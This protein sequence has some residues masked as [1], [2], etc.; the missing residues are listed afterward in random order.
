[1][2]G[3]LID[4]TR[5]IANIIPDWNCC[6]G[7]QMKVVVCIENP[8]GF[9]KRKGGTGDIPSARDITPWKPCQSRGLEGYQNQ[10]PN[11]FS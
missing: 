10:H 6:C 9:K 1:M 11:H 3:G 2:K 5:T 7:F 8:V 4:L